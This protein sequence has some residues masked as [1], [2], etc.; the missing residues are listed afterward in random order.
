MKMLNTGELYTK[1][2]ENYS[3]IHDKAN[4]TIRKQLNMIDK[5]SDYSGLTKIKYD[6]DIDKKKK[7]FHNQEFQILNIK[8]N[9]IDQQAR[10]NELHKD[11]K[12]TIAAVK[13]QQR[14]NFHMNNKNTSFRK[15]FIRAT[16]NVF[17]L[18]DKMN[19][20]DLEDIVKIYKDERLKYEGLFL[21]VNYNHLLKYTFLYPLTNF[22]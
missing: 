12:K 6:N 9:S 22:L 18:K 10:L 2:Y 4:S 16:L 20:E 1:Q 8:Q 5:L 17:I 21:L 13:E 15:E 14:Q 19:I 7:I 3:L 11:I